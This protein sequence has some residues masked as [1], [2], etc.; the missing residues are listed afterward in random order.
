MVNGLDQLDSDIRD[1][2]E[3]LEL[4]ELE[5]DQE[6]QDEVA[7]DLGNITSRLE[8]IE[9]RRMFSDASGSS[10]ERLSVSSPIIRGPDCVLGVRWCLVRRGSGSAVIRSCVY[11]LLD[12]NEL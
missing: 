5:E 10:T 11:A 9:F 3:L 4:A 12:M 6:T 1:A 2:L 7:T 8:K